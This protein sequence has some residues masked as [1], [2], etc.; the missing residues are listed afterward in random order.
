[1]ILFILAIITFLALLAINFL[2]VPKKLAILSATVVLLILLNFINEI[3][4]FSESKFTDFAIA[5]DK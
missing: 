5:L 1:M 3:Q 4:A 2:T